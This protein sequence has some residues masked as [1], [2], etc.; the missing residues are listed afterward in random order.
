MSSNKSTSKFI[1]LILRHKPYTIGI[2][3]DEHGWAKVSEL[4]DVINATGKH[5]IDMKLPEEIV[6]TGEKYTD[7]IDSS[8]LCPMS[9]LYVH[10]S[11][12]IETARKVGSRHG[13]PVK[14][15][16]KQFNNYS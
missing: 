4:M 7:S 13:K 3:L 9:R 6:R 10:L 11:S 5:R 12:D 15:L 2:S 8:G 14:Y 16:E 1:A